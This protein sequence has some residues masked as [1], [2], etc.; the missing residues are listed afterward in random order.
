MAGDERIVL[1][2]GATGHQ[3]GATARELG[4]NGFKLRGM[5]RKPESDAARALAK[6]GVQIVK[7]DL[8]VDRSCR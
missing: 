8:N 5:T 7:G 4:G 6:L 2:T 1:I 3:G